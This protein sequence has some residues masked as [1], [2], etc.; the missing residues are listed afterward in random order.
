MRPAVACLAAAAALW[1]WGGP[2]AAHAGP[3]PTVVAVEL[4]SPHPMPEELVRQAIGELTGRPLSRLAVRESLERL[5]SLGLFSDVEV[6]E[7]SEA[8][9]IRLRYRL[10]RRP[11]IRRIAWE[12]APGLSLVE[13]VEAAGLGVDGAGGPERLEKVRRDI[14]AV[15]ARE[16]Y[17][18]ARVTVS[19]ETD[20]ATNG[21]DVAVFLDPG[22]QARIGSIRF[23][24][25]ADA[26]ATR[27]GKGLDLDPGDRF[28]EATLRQRLRQLEGALRQDGYFEARIEAEPPAWDGATNMVSVVVEVSQGPR[29]EVEFHGVQALRESSLRARLT[30]G[31]AG[32]VDEGEI[33]ASARSIEAAYREDGY[34]FARAVGAVE[35]GGD[36]PVLVFTVT[37]GPQVIVE[38]IQFT[39]N[40]AFPA[41]RLQELIQ[42]KTPGFLRKGLFRQDVLDRD[43]LILTGFY[44]TQGFPDAV[45]GPA[46]VRFSEDQQQARIH[47]PIAEGPRL[48]VGAI[49]VE[50]ATAVP[51]AEILAA[52]P[53]K[54]GGPWA[55]SQLAETRRVVERLF[56]RRGYLGAQVR[57]ESARHEDR[58]DVSIR[59]AEGLQTRIGRILIEGLTT[60]R[61]EVVRREFTFRAKDP[62]DPEEAAGRELTIRPGDP[63]NPEALVELEKRL[64]RLGI[65]ERV[66]VGPLRPPSVPYVDVQIALREG[67]PWRLDFGGG[68]GTSYGWRVFV[69]LG[70]ENLFGTGQS[71]SLRQEVGEQG[72]RT[73]LTYRSPWVFGTPW[74]GDVTL[75]QEWRQEIGYESFGA[76]GA[77]GIQRELFPEWITS[78]RGGLRYQ[79]EWVRLSDVDPSLAA[80]DIVPGEQ[81]I[82]KI[83]P[84]LTLDRR[85]SIL[86]PAQGSLHSIAVDLA[87]APIGSEVD[88]VKAQL[89][90][91][92]YLDVLPPTVIAL[93]GRLGLATPFASSSALPVTERLFAGGATT[94]RGYPRDRVGPTDS[95]GNPTG[96]NAQVIFNAEW[97]VPV[98][99]WLSIAGFVDTGTVAPEVSDLGSAKFSTGVG[100]GI[101]LRTPV[102]PIRFDAG[103]ALNPI[104]DQDRWQFYLTIGNPF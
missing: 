66:Q 40:E 3:A 59:V 70:H 38:S 67:K 64:Y 57:V 33:A 74:Q 8:A 26:E 83:T 77:V 49:R 73:D 30:F 76:G 96:G 20:P 88:F 2:A 97:R 61:A 14:L 93:A 24:G 29:Y 22:E 94:I 21:T 5:W 23:R 92:W 75:F 4:E 17:F 45:V 95:Q 46:E 52:I 78:L 37:E 47:L 6:E 44:R 62:L 82:A 42:T 98:W 65:F 85:D 35:R 10:I 86:N 48:T 11:F 16:G 50:G 91:A 60:T 101:R 99:R 15:Y 1:A 71:A 51:V 39:G 18:A 84:A 72:E 12:G 90:T 43:L 53:L 13:V 25:A 36:G 55:A 54:G 80:A 100:G 103:Y 31:D 27:L 89:A 69:E 63:L 9:G 32:V 41:P 79:A 56:A 58:A 81:L 34:A 28:S 19:A 102:G 68:Y 7:A 87:A 104:P